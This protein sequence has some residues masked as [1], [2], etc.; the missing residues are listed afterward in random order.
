[1]AG[2]LARTWRPRLVLAGLACAVVGAAPLLP[3]LRDGILPPQN[4]RLL[5]VSDLGLCLAAAGAVAGGGRARR[6]LAGLA[7]AI[8]LLLAGLRG[9]W[10]I[11]DTREWAN[12][13]RVAEAAIWRARAAAAGEEAGE[14]PLLY[15]RFPVHWEGAY[16]LGYGIA[17]RF[18]APFPVSPRSVWPARPVYGQS[19]SARPAIAAAEEGFVRPWR[20]TRDR[21]P[22]LPVTVDGL[23]DGAAVPVDERVAAAGPDTSPVL[24]VGGSFPA[25]RLE[26]LLYTELGYEP[27]AWTEAG[28]AAE[29][30]LS[31]RELVRLPGSPIATPGDVLVLTADFGA[32]SAY[33]EVRA[34]RAADGAILAASRW[35]ALEWDEDLVDRLTEG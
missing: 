6:R 1:A 28:G 35:L 30:R 5:E 32:T 33:L 17:D 31:L 20:E 11:A 27:F 18:R 14:V 7:P 12:S 4:A 26:L 2:G 15:E 34:V 21:V 22:I 9:G 29:H 3:L 19:R 24:V 8:L 10:A 23:P 25:A 13:G 16:C